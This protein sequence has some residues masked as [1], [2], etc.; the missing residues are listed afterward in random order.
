MKKNG[1]VLFFAMFFNLILMMFDSA[2]ARNISF[3][4]R[5]DSGVMYYEFECEAFS[6]TLRPVSNYTQ[7][8]FKY[9]D[10][11]P[12][13]TVGGTLFINRFFLDLNGQY[14]FSGHD[15]TSMAE[16]IYFW[17][18]Y[19]ADNNFMNSYYSA[20]TYE[21]S[22]NIDRHD[23]AVSLGY[24]LN[25]KLSI[26]AGYKWAETQFDETFDGPFTDR[27]YNQID[28]T[29][30]DLDYYS[31]YNWG[32]STFKFNYY[33]PFI[34]FIQ[35][36]D[37]SD[38]RLLKGMLAANVAVA[39]LEGKVDN[40]YVNQHTSITCINGEQIPPEEVEPTGHNISG[41]RDT[42]GDAL[43]LTVGISWRGMTALEGLSYSVG[44]SAY[45]YEFDS[46]N[47]N[48]IG[49]DINETA[50]TFKLGLAYLF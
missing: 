25:R 39:Y 21:N 44:I 41:Q 5:L 10:Y 49:R 8:A 50:V 18:S 2:M 29:E 31:G 48:I 4:P 37:F 9:S 38:V 32:Q 33:G 16:S 20:C 27:L 3:Q 14:A 23:I 11:M 47:K 43:G 19:D 7:S 24:T 22:V 17:S 26:F 46:E 6:R 42:K 1:I 13:L 36:W 35:G 40:T 30:D 45:R 12:F 15:S 34:G 28:D